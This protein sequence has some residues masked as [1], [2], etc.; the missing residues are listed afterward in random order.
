MKDLISLN[1]YALA[2]ARAEYGEALACELRIKALTE[3]QRSHRQTAIRLYKQAGIK[4]ADIRRI[5]LIPEK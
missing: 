3:R 2:E 4:T 1:Y 5:M